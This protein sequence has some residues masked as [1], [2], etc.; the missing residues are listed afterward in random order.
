M[1]G[2]TALSAR[3]MLQQRSMFP[4]SVLTVDE[5]DESL[6]LKLQRLLFVHAATTCLANGTTVWYLFTCGAVMKLHWGVGY[7]FAA[8]GMDSLCNT[9]CALSL[10]GL[11]EAVCM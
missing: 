2:F 11:I 3:V 5:L 4:T 9:I 8:H 10:S 1:G 6:H 7:Y